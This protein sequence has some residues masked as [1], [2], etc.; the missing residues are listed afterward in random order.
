VLLLLLPVA[1]V[2]AIS[3]GVFLLP[4]FPLLA[5]AIWSALGH[6]SAPRDHDEHGQTLQ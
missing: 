1:A 6:W 3:M 2:W 4:I 5:W